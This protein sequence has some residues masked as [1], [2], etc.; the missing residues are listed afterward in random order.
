MGAEQ[1]Q[2]PVEITTIQLLLW[3]LVA[4]PLWVLCLP[5]YLAVWGWRWLTGRNVKAAIWMFTGK[6]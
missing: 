6:P 2:K 1:F 4:V 5:V 3:L